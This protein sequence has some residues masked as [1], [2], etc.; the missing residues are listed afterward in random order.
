MMQKLNEPMTQW[1][2]P[3]SHIKPRLTKFSPI[4]HDF[5]L[6]ICVEDLF[7][8]MLCKLCITSKYFNSYITL[9]LGFETYPRNKLQ[10][11]NSPKESSNKKKK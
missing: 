7:N 9:F 5:Q 3:N 8:S 11:L 1:L 2:L 6:D 10:S 4:P